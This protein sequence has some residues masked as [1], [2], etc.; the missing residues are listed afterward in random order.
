MPP[1]RSDPFYYIL[2]G[3]PDLAIFLLDSTGHVSRWSSSAEKMF[4]YP[5]KEILGRHFSCLYA[6][7]S[8]KTSIA[9]EELE[10]AA[11]HGRFEDIDWRIRKNQS[12]F[13]ADCVMCPM[14]NE[15]GA[16]EGFSVVV[17][18]ITERRKTDESLRQKEAEL[19]QARKLE[20]V[21]RLA[22]GVAHDFNNYLTGI[23]GLAEDIRLSMTEQD[24]RRMDLDLIIKTAD[25]A[26]LLTRELLAFGRR[27]VTAPMVI[28]LN[29]HIRE[30]QN[31][32]GR[33]LGPAIHLETD[34]DPDV[35]KLLIDPTQLDQILINLVMNA[36]DAMPRGGE[37]RIKTDRKAASRNGA[38]SDY[39]G[40]HVLLEISDSGTGMDEKT[41]AHIFEPFFTTKDQGKGTGLGLATVYGIVKQNHGDIQVRSQLGKGTTFTIQFPEIDA[42]LET[43]A[44]ATPFLPTVASETILV[45]ED[46]DVVRRVAVQ[47]LEKGG[48][49][50]LSA[51]SGKE[52]LECAQQ[53]HETIHLLLTDVVMPEINGRKLAQRLTTLHPESAVLYMSAYAEDFSRERDLSHEGEA[54]IEKPFT[55]DSLLQ[56]VRD[57][58]DHR[59]ISTLTTT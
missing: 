18:D 47:I 48:Y 22:G 26:R 9:Q 45:V 44:D 37:I 53:M 5:T 19:L 51:A 56:K 14:R 32:L 33:L 2:D 13:W 46:T 10:M 40:A 1:D 21:G 43:P 36:R 52:A 57:V 11:A 4:D 30:K 35:R 15:S 59:Q 20:A 42:P 29:A 17:R 24:P 23:S 27:Q 6:A 16:L 8:D 58:L 3:I 34:L 49:R 41:M 12:R 25:Q 55:G 31:I 38:G 54:F 28:P 50:V 7:D 39:S